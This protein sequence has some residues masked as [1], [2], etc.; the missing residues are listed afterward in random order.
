MRTQAMFRTV[1]AGASSAIGTVNADR[2]G[3]NR[4]Q[5][6]TDSSSREVLVGS[7]V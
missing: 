6:I 1:I 3:L 2:L 7:S 5:N 4:L